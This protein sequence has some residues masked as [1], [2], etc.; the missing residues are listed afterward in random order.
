VVT[1]VNPAHLFAFSTIPPEEH[2]A[3]GLLEVWRTR[4]APPWQ[5]LP[6]S[7]HGMLFRD[8][9]VC[10]SVSDDGLHSGHS[11]P[12]HDEGEDPAL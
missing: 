10:I 2:A 8:T 12:D 7:N 11:R 3:S 4:H 1:H 5:T 9:A 6:F